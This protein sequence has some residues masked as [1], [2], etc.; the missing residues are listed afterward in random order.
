[1]FVICYFKG[2]DAMFGDAEHY[3]YLTNEADLNNVGDDSIA[4]TPKTPKK[5][6]SKLITASPQSPGDSPNI[7]SQQVQPPLQDIVLQEQIAS[8]EQ[9]NISIDSK[10]SPQPSSK[11]QLQATPVITGANKKIV[12]GS[13]GNMSMAESMDG[14][15]YGGYDSNKNVNS[16]EADNIPVESRPKAAG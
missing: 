6:E 5:E 9:Q 3:K 4:L 1:M 11:Q 10:S 2:D 15:F 12:A 8:P 14:S 16:H 7:K 13:L